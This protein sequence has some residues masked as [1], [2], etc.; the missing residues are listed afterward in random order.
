MFDDGLRIEVAGKPVTFQD[1]LIYY[2]DDK[3]PE[4]SMKH[5]SAGVI[6]VVVVVVLAI[7]AGI[8][9]L[10]CFLCIYKLHLKQKWY[11]FP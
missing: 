11:T 10:V 1:T 8:L 6:A 3:P 2:R 9:V 4:F 7:V 5:L